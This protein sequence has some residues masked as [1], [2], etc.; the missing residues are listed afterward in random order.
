M[1][2]RIENPNRYTNIL[3]IRKRSRVRTSGIRDLPDRGTSSP[4]LPH[5]HISALPSRV[6]KSATHRIRCQRQIPHRP[7]AHRPIRLIHIQ[8]VPPA[9]TSYR[10]RRDGECA[11]HSR[12]AEDPLRAYVARAQ[13]GRIDGVAR[14]GIVVEVCEPVVREEQRAAAD[15]GVTRRKGV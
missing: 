1:G 9:L 6:P 13:R 15:Y 4:T 10:T 7:N 2:S 3:H 14:C 11:P 5:T 8:F 12:R